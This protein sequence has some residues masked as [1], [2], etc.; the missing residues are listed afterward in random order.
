[1]KGT[2]SPDDPSAYLENLMHA[3]Q[4]SMKRF[5]DALAAA[6]GVSDK[7]SAPMGQVFSPF[8]FAIDMQR[9]YVTQIWRF[10]N[11]AV[12][13]TLTLGTKPAILPVRGDKRF[14]DQAWQ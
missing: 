4:Q 14:K 2:S 9:E 5:D 10:W 3:G 7:S 6:M 11:A 12:I 13:G 1:M 8:A